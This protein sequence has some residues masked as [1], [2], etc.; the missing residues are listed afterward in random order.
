MIQ[1]PKRNNTL[2]QINDQ[3]AG[4]SK[5]RLMNTAEKLLMS[6][7]GYLADRLYYFERQKK[8]TTA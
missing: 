8:H 1:N 3:G 4:Q 2:Q 6:R 5:G 7:G